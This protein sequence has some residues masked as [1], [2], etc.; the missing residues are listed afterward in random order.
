MPDE[1]N[2]T[3][4]SPE[5]TP[6]GPSGPQSPPSGIEPIPVPD[7]GF[8]LPHKIENPPWPARGPEPFIIKRD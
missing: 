8:D 5:Q 6:S 4:Q 3:P 7:W 2:S 1:P